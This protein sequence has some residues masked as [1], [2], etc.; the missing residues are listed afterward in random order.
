MAR[1]DDIIGLRD[2]ERSFRELGKVPQTVATQSARA[3][4]SVARR[5]A[6]ANA[7]EDTGALKQAIIMKRERRSKRGKAVYDILIDPS[8][9]DQFV[10]ISKDGKRS[11]YPASQEYGFFTVDGRYIPGYGYLR[12]A[13]DDNRRE[14]ERAA[15]KRAT[16]AI[17]KAMR[18]K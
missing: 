17:D 9:N 14:I 12:R 8:K 18:K 2:L 1:K 7:P 11:Y 15:L 13:V 5:A 10:K 6:K 4:A 3:G 16:V